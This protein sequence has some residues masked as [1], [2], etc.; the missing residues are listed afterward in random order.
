MMLN[1]NYSLCEYE[2]EDLEDDI[3]DSSLKTTI[4]N[5]PEQPKKTS[6]DGMF[7]ER[8]KDFFFMAVAN[9]DNGTMKC[10]ACRKNPYR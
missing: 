7:C 10:Y 4:S 8:C 1:L 2:W 6:Q 3:D 5:K 9:Q